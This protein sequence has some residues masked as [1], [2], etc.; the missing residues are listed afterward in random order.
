MTQYEFLLM[1]FSFIAVFFYTSALL[2][3]FEYGFRFP[4]NYYEGVLFYCGTLY[5]LYLPDISIFIE[6]Y[7]GLVILRS[8]LNNLW[9][10]IALYAAI[11][12][13][14][15]KIEP[16]YLFLTSITLPLVIY[17]ITCNIAS[18]PPLLSHIILTINVAIY[19]YW[20]YY[21]NKIVEDQDISDNGK[22]FNWIRKWTY[23]LA[24]ILTIWSV[25]RIFF[26]YQWFG[27]LIDVFIYLPAI[28]IFDNRYNQIL[29][30]ASSEKDTITLCLT[31][32]TIMADKTPTDIA[33]NAVI[34]EDTDYIPD[35]TLYQ[36]IQKKLEALER[37]GKFYLKSTLSI[38]E[39]ADKLD[40][41]RTYL[42]LYFSARNTSFSEYIEKLRVDHSIEL[43]KTEP[44]STNIDI[45]STRSG[46]GSRST[47][48]K[49]FAK[50]YGT[51]PN[52]YRERFK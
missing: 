1:S 4:C 38:T 47:Y 36:S 10:P 30:K 8:I 50:R 13:T 20:G 17:S 35:N 11:K 2:H 25:H 37:K 31:D 9:I 14:K 19:F 16:Y 21:S 51:T 34:I 7:N 48:Y 5:L 42:S 28:L 12:I 44:S 27:F 46:F 39:L 49:A 23:N 6:Q 41:N 26:P 15:I 32:D 24:I 43:M 45:I 33:V 40:T 29:K 18:L 22:E 3:I 52:K